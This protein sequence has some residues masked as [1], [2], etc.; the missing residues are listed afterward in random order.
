MA[1]K[2]QLRECRAVKISVAK[3]QLGLASAAKYKMMIACSAKTH[4]PVTWWPEQN[5]I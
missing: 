4:V 5:Y 1:F 3:I 2:A